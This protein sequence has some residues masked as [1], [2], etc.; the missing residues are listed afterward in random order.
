MEKGAEMLLRHINSNSHIHVVIDSDCDGY[1][2][3]A[4]LINYLKIAYPNAKITYNLHPD[5][6]HGIL[7]EELPIG[8]DLVI[9]PDSSSNQYE[10]HEQ[11]ASERI[12]ILVLDHH[13]AEYY[14]EHACVINNQLSQKYPNK[15]LSG[16]GVTYKFCSYLDY[17]RGSSLTDR[18]LDLVALGMIADVMDLRDFETRHLIKQGLKNVQNPYFKGMVEK[19]SYSLGGELT[20][21]GVAFYIAPYV[22]AVVRVGTQD[23]KLVLFESMLDHKAFEKIPSTK[24][25]CKGQY[26]TRVEQACRNCANVKNRQTKARD[27]SLNMIERIIEEENLLKNQILLIRL[28]KPVETNLTGLIAN[29]LMDEYKKPVLLLN[30]TQDGWAGSGRN[31]NGSEFSNFREF[32]IESNL[33][34]Y[35]EGHAS[36]FGAAISADNV[37]KLLTYSNDVL[38]DYD[39]APCYNVDFI[40]ENG[41]F[42]KQD[43]LDIAELKTL[44]GQGIEESLI[45]VKN[46]KVTAQNITLMSKDKN[47]TLKIV[48][49]NLVSAIKFR[50]NNDEYQELYSDLGCVTINI[51]GKCERNIWNGTISPQ[52][53]IKEIEIVDR[54][55]YYF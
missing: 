20:P 34:Q 1:T 13:E 53:I 4:L 9:A 8:V 23:E 44:W 3:A 39:F 18:F 48:L 42:N 22:N 51:V 49:P 27:A 41:K 15:T 54:T 19:Q 35:A 38:A 40:Y 17:I 24:R 46:V 55:Q 6:E 45:L 37:D 21:I 5:K 7:P 52:I 43:I 50:S 16:V 47:P 33:M 11:L 14:S 30:K 31:V 29:S 32:L 25:G 26:E 28:E 2:S 36:A 12:D 10:I